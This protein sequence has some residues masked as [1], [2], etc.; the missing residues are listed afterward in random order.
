MTLGCVS[1][2]VYQERNPH[3]L[4]N[5]FMQE[6]DLYVQGESW[7]ATLLKI[8]GGGMGKSFTEALQ[9]LVEMQAIPSV[10]LDLYSEFQKHI[11]IEACK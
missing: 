7:C 10:N 4:L 11:K 3:N 8:S 2:I 1:P 9:L 6:F 5:D